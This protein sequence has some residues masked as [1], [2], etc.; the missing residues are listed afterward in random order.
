[1]GLVRRKRRAIVRTEERA[2]L[3]LDGFRL[4]CLLRRSSA[5]RT[6]AMRVDNHGRVVVN[7]PLT[8]PMD[9]MGAFVRRHLDWLRRQLR[10]VCHADEPWREGALLP[11]LGDRLRLEEATGIERPQRQADCLRVPDIAGAHAS[12]PAWYRAEAPPLLAARL[13]ALCRQ[14]DLPLPLWRLSDA[15]TRWGSLSAKGVVG[16]N[17]RLIKASTAEIDYV[18]CHELAHFR[19]RNHS[20]AFWRE[21]ATLCPD[22]AVARRLLRQNARLYFQ[23]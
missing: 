14:H 8:M 10:Q 15:R 4:A 20:P 6:L 16:L 17:W 19:Q 23:F 22:Y 7:M 18:I 2:E 3:D 21:V 13:H 12:V 1:M 9:Y 11:Y 5:R